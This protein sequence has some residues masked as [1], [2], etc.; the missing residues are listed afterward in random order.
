MIKKQFNWKTVVATAVVAIIFFIFAFF[1]DWGEVWQQL[2]QADYGYLLL[3][4]ALLLVGLVGYAVRWRLLMRNLPSLRRTFHASNIGHA[5]NTFLPARAGEA[6]RIIVI[7][8]SDNVSKTEATTSFIVERLVEQFMRLL[9][10]GLAVGLGLGIEPSAAS[11]GGGI[12]TLVAAVLLTIWLLNNRQRVMQRGPQLLSRLPGIS[13]ARAQSGLINLL[14]NL[15]TIA[16]PRQFLRVLLWSL[17]PWIFFAG[18]HYF[19]L[20]A[21]GDI[22]GDTN[23]WLIALATLAFCPPSAPTNPGVYH[24]FL[25]GPLL[26][27]GYGREPAT[28]YAVMLHIVQ[29]L[30]T[31]LLALWG[32]TQMGLSLGELFRVRNVKRDA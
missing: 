10:L 13:P 23:L 14:N 19:T 15:D 27:L 3:A 17:I 31:L 4:S 22:F 6:A 16:A 26:A 7:S 2:R 1:I 21:L 32:V 8:N 20:L 18:F 11:V 24:A 28:A 5:G 9:A 30:W 29:S 25:I 12:A